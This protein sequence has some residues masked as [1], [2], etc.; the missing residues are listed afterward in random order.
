MHFSIFRHLLCAVMHV[1]GCAIL[2]AL[3]ALFCVLSCILSALFVLADRARQQRI[4]A[5]DRQNYEDWLETIGKIRAFDRERVAFALSLT[6]DE[7]L[8]LQT[9]LSRHPS[10]R[11]I[12]Y[13][14]QISFVPH[15]FIAITDYDL[16]SGRNPRTRQKT[17][18]MAE[19]ITDVL[20]SFKKEL[21]LLRMRKEFVKQHLHKRLPCQDC[22]HAVA[23][24]LAL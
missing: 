1:L 16:Y 8:L 5:R 17:P 14:R 15:F 6:P 9:F 2:H 24:A 10:Y 12:S 21:C 20:D 13:R 7:T 3:L 11:E 23:A 4:A 22:C 19:R 18:S